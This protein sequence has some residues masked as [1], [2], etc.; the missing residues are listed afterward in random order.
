MTLRY[1]FWL[2]TRKDEDAP[3][4]QVSHTLRSGSELA[5]KGRLENLITE[6]QPLLDFQGVVQ[7]GRYINDPGDSREKIFEESGRSWLVRPQGC[8]IEWV[9]DYALE[10]VQPWAVSL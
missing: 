1:E 5:A 2:E 3:L 10:D 9:D 8:T 7:E 4:K 6:H